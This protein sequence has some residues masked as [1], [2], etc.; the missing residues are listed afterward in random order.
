MRDGGRI[1]KVFREKIGGSPLLIYMNEYDTGS[2][3]NDFI[4]N[5]FC[6]HLFDKLLSSKFAENIQ[7]EKEKKERLIN[8]QV[9]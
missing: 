8:P 7:K 2:R 1:Q 9:G 5:F 3:I 4:F 6:F